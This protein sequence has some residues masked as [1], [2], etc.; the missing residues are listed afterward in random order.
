M[1]QNIIII[2]RRSLLKIYNRIIILSFVLLLTGCS[3][4]AILNTS[5]CDDNESYL[6]RRD[7]VRSLNLRYKGTRY[8]QIKNDFGRPRR[9]EKEGKQLM[10]I[11]EECAKN[12][13]GVMKWGDCEAG[14]ADEV[15]VYEFKDRDKCG[16]VFYSRSFAFVD[17]K[18]IEIR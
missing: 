16:W 6:Q 15:W 2:K 5:Q 3:W 18:V 9:I 12:W 13:E 11:D 17:G 8:A 14:R 10:L 4:L 7:E 1:E